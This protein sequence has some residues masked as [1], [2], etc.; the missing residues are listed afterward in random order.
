MKISVEDT[1]APSLIAPADVVAECTGPAGTPVSIGE[2]LLGDEEA[3][4]DPA[5][6]ARIAGTPQGR[7][8][9]LL[10]WNWRQPTA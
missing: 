3:S 2:A 8:S 4:I 10:Q 1:T 5:V 6:L 9:E 7:L